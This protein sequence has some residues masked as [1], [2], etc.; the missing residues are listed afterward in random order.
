MGERHVVVADA[1]V[2]HQ[3]PARQSLRHIVAAVNLVSPGSTDT[4][5]NFADGESA[6]FQRS[7]SSL[8]SYAEPREIA[9]VVVFLASS[10][11][12][13]VTGSIVTADGGANA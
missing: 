2:A 8:G 13:M 11:A 1:V 6:D 10:A 3:Q 4:E 5:S 12:N 7:L 9:D